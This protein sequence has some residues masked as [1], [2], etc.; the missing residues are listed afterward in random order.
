MK[1]LKPEPTI[2]VK[3]IFKKRYY[4]ILPNIQE[5]GVYELPV[6]DANRV[7]EEKKKQDGETKP[8]N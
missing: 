3:G 2:I 1:Y 8:T 5:F 4:V 6:H 7:S